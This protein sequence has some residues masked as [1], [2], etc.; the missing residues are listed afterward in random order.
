M[1]HAKLSMGQTYSLIW[2]ALSLAVIAVF[3]SQTVWGVVYVRLVFQI[4]PQASKS[5]KLNSGDV[6]MSCLILMSHS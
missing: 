3:K 6:T 2:I 1:P 4:P 5:E